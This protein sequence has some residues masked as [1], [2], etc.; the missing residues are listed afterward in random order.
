MTAR[1]LFGIAVRVIGLWVLVQGVLYILLR[2]PA[3]G[4]DVVWPLNVNQ[5]LLT[6]SSGIVEMLVGAWVLLKADTIV[7]LVYG[8]PAKELGPE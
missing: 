4:I 6:W 3:I 8:A 5:L 2:L 1:E 7:C